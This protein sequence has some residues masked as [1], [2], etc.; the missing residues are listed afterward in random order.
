MMTKRIKRTTNQSKPS[1]LRDFVEQRLTKKMKYSIREMQ[2]TTHMEQNLSRTP[3]VQKAWIGKISKEAICNVGRIWELRNTL[4]FGRY[5]SSRRIS[6]KIF[7]MKVTKLHTSKESKCL[8][9]SYWNL[10][11]QKLIGFKSVVKVIG[12]CTIK[13]SFECLD[14]PSDSIEL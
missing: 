1:T 5:A 12:D 11:W 4:P 14:I 2:R 13:S 9:W 3:G 8:S 7:D 6:T 10:C